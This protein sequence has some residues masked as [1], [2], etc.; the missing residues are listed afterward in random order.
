[1]ILSEVRS[2]RAEGRSIKV[3]I[4]GQAPSDYDDFATFLVECGI[5]QN[6]FPVYIEKTYG[7]ISSINQ[8]PV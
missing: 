5:D 1:M 3:G 7:I 4:C 6:D 2:L 8:D